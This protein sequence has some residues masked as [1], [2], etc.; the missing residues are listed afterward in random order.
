VKE[1]ELAT[2]GGGCFWC[3][4]AV[5]RELRGVFRVV[6]GYAG[7]HV[8]NPTYRQ[9]CGGDTGHAEAVQVTF[10]P[11]VI[12]FGELLE[13][14]WHVHDPTTR[15]RQGADVGSQYRSVIFYHNEQQKAAAERS[16]G[17]A[18]AA[19][20]GPIV[21]EIVPF[22]RFYEAED[23]HH[24]YYRQ[25]ASQP[26]CRMVIDPKLRKLKDTLGEKLR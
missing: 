25:N 23:Y 16:R 26:Y 18:S 21:T 6:P 12:S 15:D 19:W 9:V 11:A 22:T 2:L 13:V 17:D 8:V 7:G 24:D 14:F 4:D 10:D 3:L 5:Y 20:P 1:H